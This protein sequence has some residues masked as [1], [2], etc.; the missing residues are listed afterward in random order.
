MDSGRTLPFLRPSQNETNLRSRHLS[1]HL[2]LKDACVQ[3]LSVSVQTRISGETKA[4]PG[5]DVKIFSI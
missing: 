5:P 1:T 2:Y 4:D 3:E